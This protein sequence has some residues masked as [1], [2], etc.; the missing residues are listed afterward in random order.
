MNFNSIGIHKADILVVDD[1]PDNIRF[2]ATLL[3]E[4]DFF[5]R[6]ALSG[7]MALTAVQTLRPDLILLDV[8]MPGMNGYEVCQRLKEN[9]QT[10]SIPIIF[11]SALDSTADKI[12]AFQAGGVDYITKPFQ[13][14]EVLARI[15]TQL[16]LQT[17]QTQIQDQNQQL[18][19][20][21]DD[22]KKAQSQLV[23]HEKMSG[24]G[25]LAAG[26]SH[27]INNPLSFIASN[28]APA[29]EYIQDL[30]NLIQLYQQEYPHPTPLIQ[31]VTEAI[32]LNFLIPDLQNL[33]GSMEIGTNRIRSIILSLRIFSRLD[34]SD[35]KS[36]NLHEGMDSTLLL[37]QQRLASQPKH[38]RIE[39]VKNYGD[40]PPITC[41]AS[42]VNQVFLNLLN[43]AIEALRPDQEVAFFQPDPTIWISTQVNALEMVEIHIKDNGVG[44]SEAAQTRLFEPF[45]TTKQV[46][47][48][49]GLGLSISYE[50]VVEK[51]KGRLSYYSAEGKGTEFVVEVPIRLKRGS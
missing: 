6:K 11:L 13:F 28:L 41:Y 37:L 2:L 21:L 31:G 34:E 12:K 48:G 44:I 46:G 47:D 20:A 45:Y 32:D 4:H 25:Q 50:I 42:Q 10:A 15:Q 8:N 39:V 5:V 27:E 33:L 30:L 1:T 9:P 26:F 23:Q 18:Q 29:R 38:P 36:V 3:L 51:H 24:L 49:A 7:Q 22:L 17:L 35:I 43:N 16:T 40:I 19:Q 14:E